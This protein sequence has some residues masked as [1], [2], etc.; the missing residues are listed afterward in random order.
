MVV[1]GVF[2]FQLR[3]RIRKEAGDARRDEGERCGL[4]GIV[5]YYIYRVARLVRRGE[6]KMEFQTVIDKGRD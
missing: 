4:G 5:L 3:R 1:L 6:R 2:C